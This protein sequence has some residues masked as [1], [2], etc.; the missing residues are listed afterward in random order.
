[1]AVFH[2]E[3]WEAA[4]PYP[5]VDTRKA[6]SGV[7]A[8]VSP[9]PAAV[10]SDDSDIHYEHWFRTP[11]LDLDT[12]KRIKK[13]YLHTESHDQGKCKDPAAGTWTWFELAVF[14]DKIADKP[15][16][17]RGITLVWESHINVQASSE[18]MPLDGRVFH[19][20]DDMLR[21]IEPGN[22]LGVRICAQYRDW[23]L[24][25]QKGHL[26]I[27]LGRSEEK[28]PVNYDSIKAQTLQFQNII[29]D[30][31]KQLYPDMAH[32]VTLPETLFHATRV[33]TKGKRRLRVLALD[34][35][36]VRGL[37]ALTILDQ[38]MI[39]TYGERYTKKP[40]EV[41][42][43]IGGTSTGGFIAI[44]LGRLKMTVAECIEEYKAL[45]PEIFPP[46]P[47]GYNPLTK[48][49]NDLKGV[50]TAARAAWTG[51]K[52]DSSQLETL[53]KQLVEKYLKKHTG[54]TVDGNTEVLKEDDIETNE[55]SC[56][57][58]VTAVSRTD[59]NRRPPVLLR[60]YVNPD[61]M[62]E[63]PNITIWEAARA[64]SAAPSYF[65]DITVG[66]YTFV[67]GGLQAN[68]PLG[69]VWNEVLAVFGPARDTTC[70]LSIGTGVPVASILPRIELNW[71]NVKNPAAIVEGFAS[72]A[73]NT[74]VINTLFRSLINNFAPRSQVLKYWR[75]NVGDGL[76]EYIID[77]KVWE[78]SNKDGR[79]DVDIQMDDSAKVLEIE[80]QAKKY[81]E[82]DRAKDMLHECAE[83]LLQ[84]EKPIEAA[85]PTPPLDK[86]FS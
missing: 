84:A 10:K 79:G 77:K 42:D 54:K 59:S 45:M 1:M 27:E 5:M 66:G 16:V 49:W 53:I 86:T 40:C 47:E 58:F 37:A 31:N 57:V 11:P 29:G 71:A 61:E 75:F 24:Y 67:D 78:A 36:G 4:L 34:G 33:D 28:E 80:T 43:I 73:T 70:F 82:S 26:V 38:V 32:S 55:N 17:K 51:Q 15:R 72:L 41:F 19:A 12:I 60:S 50:E 3:E 20:D 63:L 9:V 14:E 52:Y 6:P 44:M 64:T 68:N 48:F 7:Y 81:L 85:L 2:Q 76:P 35:G 56:R 22:T 23:A 13:V 39:A 74:E 30:M 8:L 25:A 46:P 83:A 69:W 18:D 65:K 62:N 21:A